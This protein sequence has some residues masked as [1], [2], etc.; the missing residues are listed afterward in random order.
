MRVI[1]R[2]LLIV[3]C[4]VTAVFGSAL[5]LPV[6]SVN[7]K[8]YYYYVVKKGDTVY[9]LQKRLG[10]TRKQL[11][12]SNPGAAD[13][14]RADE[15]LLF[16]VD[17][18]GG[19]EQIVADP[20][21]SV[22]Q[23]SEEGVIVHKVKKGETLFGISRQ[24]GVNPD[25]IVALNPQAMS[26][27]KTGATLRIPVAANAVSEDVNVA[28]NEPETTSE[29]A[30]RV[31]VIEPSYDLTP[32]N[33]GVIAVEPEA[34]IVDNDAETE[35]DVEPD[36]L[37]AEPVSRKSSI[38]V[39]LPFMLNEDQP[40][41]QAALYTD[42]YKGLLLAADTLSNRG[43]TVSIYA[44]DTMGDVNRL[45]S[46]L[47]QPAVKEASVIIAPDATVQLSAIADAVKSS[48]LKVLNV[49]NVK[50]TLYLDC[51]QFVQT[52]IPHRQMYAKAVD[53]M[54]RLYPD[55]IP[56]V[57]NNQSGRNDKAEFV[58][59]MLNVYRSKGV[60]PI[61]INY[62][63][64][65]VASEFDVLP[66]DGSRYVVI[67]TSGNLNEFNKFIHAVKTARETRELA[68]FGY[69]DW[70]AFRGDA[71]ELL[72]SV[73]AAV[74]SRFYLDENS[75]DTRSF[76]QSY[77]RWYGGEMIDVVPNQALLGFD[78]GNMLIRNLR[79]NN[80][81]FDPM[82]VRYIGIQ[83]SFDFIRAADRDDAGFCN[84][85]IYI[86]RFHPGNRVERLS[87]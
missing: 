39:L 4:C 17:K 36:S 67:P 14:L 86:L 51:S 50:D 48:D 28:E 71:E 76:A 46:L 32:V 18:F 23:P 34:V 16:A 35:D 72:H 25:D 29:E 57:I 84:D 19:S 7:G 15:T 52:N 37:V 26:G 49:F 60:E 38:A 30:P 66:T 55:Y 62:D 27:V 12:E 44:F 58:A 68:L 61:E 81:S 20:T 56:V 63:G 69:P 2:S 85:D 45:K 82:T 9:S 80:G 53:A 79:T 64:A 40:G 54:L 21:P 47:D 73:D 65:L 75:F 22:A 5:D 33:P 59:Y 87:F 78:V 1:L 42:F 70:T 11:I 83:S 8:Q 24:Y 3:L 10:V 43:D 31:V 13:G 77:E 41:R 6:K 74:Y